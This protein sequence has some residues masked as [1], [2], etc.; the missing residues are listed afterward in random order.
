[1]KTCAHT[2]QSLSFFPYSFPPYSFQSFKSTLWWEYWGGEEGW[3]TFLSLD[4]FS[5]GSF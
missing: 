4:V 2:A 3:G 1:M 5:V